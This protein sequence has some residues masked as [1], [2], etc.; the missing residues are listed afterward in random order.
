MYKSWLWKLYI[1]SW[2]NRKDSNM[3]KIDIKIIIENEEV[4]GLV[5][6]V[7][8]EYRKGLSMNEAL[9]KVVLQYRNSL[10]Q[11]KNNNDSISQK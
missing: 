5:D 7:V 11:Q 6:K 2:E 9:K 4:D 10:E 8:E 1:H 3:Q